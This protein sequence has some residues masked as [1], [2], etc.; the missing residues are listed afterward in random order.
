MTEV[1][2][3]LVVAPPMSSGRKSPRRCISFA[4]PTISSSD[5]VISPDSPIMSQLSLSA[6]SRIFAVGTITPRSMTSK[7]L[8]C[9]TT[10][11]I[12]LPISWTSPFTVARTILPLVFIGTPPFSSSINGT[13]YAT[14][15]FITRADLTTCGRNILPAP[16]R[17]PTRFIP[18]IRD[19]S[20]TSRGLSEA[21]RAS[22]TSSKTYV[23]TPLTNE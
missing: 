11:T 1:C 13:K 23:S 2:A 3:G 6:I 19:P 9:S 16:K 10:P 14:A 17:S 15:F 18:S 4:T 21:R 22:S 12:F 5:G 7:L 8:H 20:M